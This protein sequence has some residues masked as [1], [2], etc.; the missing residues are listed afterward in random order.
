MTKTPIQV[1][2]PAVSSL[3]QEL[4]Q[5]KNL[6][7]T[8]QGGNVYSVNG[9]LMTKEGLDALIQ[10]KQSTIDALP[11]MVDGSDYSPLSYAGAA[12]ASPGINRCRILIP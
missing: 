7:P 9:S 8:Q 3:Q 11:Q 4:N 10:Q 6:Q 12:N 1:T 5:I 2:N